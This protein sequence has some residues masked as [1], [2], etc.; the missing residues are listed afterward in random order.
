VTPMSD[1][2]TAVKADLHKGGV[3]TA[4]RLVS[5]VCAS[6][7]ATVHAVVAP[8]HMSES[9][10]VGMFFIVVWAGQA[11][12]ALVLASGKPLSQL[13][14]LGAI[15]AN[16]GI[17][18][19]YVASRTVGLTFLPD[20]DHTAHAVEHLPVAGAIGN[21]VPVLSESHAEPVGSLDLVCLVAE[22]VLVVVLVGMLR[23]RAQ[24]RVVNTMLGMGLLA[25]GARAVGLLA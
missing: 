8:E 19:L 1:T 16:L 3:E 14:L 24:R 4:C 13:P 10:Y 15:G 22:L 7:A 17:V 9:W 23:G 20:H 12:L 2:R 21:G 5:C 6:V 18:V 25:L 11:G